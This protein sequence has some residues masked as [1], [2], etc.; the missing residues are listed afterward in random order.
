MQGCR[1]REG[2]GW[3]GTGGLGAGPCRLWGGDVGPNGEVPVV[4]SEPPGKQDKR[5]E[6]GPSGPSRRSAGPWDGLG[7]RV[8][9][10][11]VPALCLSLPV[12]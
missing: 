3:G 4:H 8:Q 5:P 11:R 10:L 2:H 12:S 1:P 7:L 6:G 9:M